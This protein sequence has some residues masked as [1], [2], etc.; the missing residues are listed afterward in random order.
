MIYLKK[1]QELKIDTGMVVCGASG[2][3]EDEDTVECA[4]SFAPEDSVAR[5]EAKFIAYGDAVYVISDKER[6]MEVLK[7]I[8]PE[9]LF[10][11][12]SAEVGIDKKIENITKEKNNSET[13]QE[14]ESQNSQNTEEPSGQQGNG[15]VTP[16]APSKGAIASEEAVLSE[17]LSTQTLE[18][19][20]GSIVDVSAVSVETTSLEALPEIVERSKEI[21]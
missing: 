8:D 14:G 21:L 3:Y 19:S 15:G 13:E 1:G 2:Y 10:G 12:T 6:L 7:D 4:M 5:F 11:K 18:M 16:E 9:T 20:N 17:D